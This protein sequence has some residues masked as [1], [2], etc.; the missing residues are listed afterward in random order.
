M[1]QHKV[2]PAVK[3]LQA[4]PAQLF[5]QPGAL[6][7]QQGAGLL[8]MLRLAQR[9]QCR[10]LRRAVYSEAGPGGGHLPHQLP[11]GG[12]GI[13]HPQAGH[14]PCLGEAVHHHKTRAVHR[15][16]FEGMLL[17]VPGQLDEALVHH[18]Q[19]IPFGARL[20]QI[21]QLAA[22]QK[23]P[24][25]VARVAQH[26]HLGA[27]QRL[28]HRCGIRHKA[29]LRAG[30]QMHQLTA[31]RF[32]RPGVFLVCRLQNHRLFRADRP[33]QTPD[34][35]VRAGSHEHILGQHLVPVRQSCAQGGAVRVGICIGGGQGGG[36]GLRCCGRHTQRVAAA[37][38][39]Q[40]AHGQRRHGRGLNA[41]KLHQRAGQS[42]G[43]VKALLIQRP[44]LVHVPLGAG[45]G[46]RGLRPDHEGFSLLLQLLDAAHP[47]V[48]VLRLMQA[49]LH[50]LGVGFV[51]AAVHLVDGRALALFAEALLPG[52]HHHQLARREGQLLRQRDAAGDAA[53]QADVLA[54]LHH[55]AQQR[56]AA[57]GPAGG[58]ELLAHLLVVVEDGL[59]GAAVGG[60]RPHALLR[61][62]EGLVI[63]GHQFMAQLAEHKIKVEEAEG[64]QQM[65]R[66]HIPGIVHI[67]QVDVPAAARLAGQIT[68]GIQR[69]GAHAHHVGNPDSQL[70]QRVQHTGGIHPPQCA[71]FQNQCIGLVHVLSL[72]SSG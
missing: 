69:T 37:G 32:Q 27:F 23:G 42:H 29:L 39:I 56:H 17:P 53:V 9:R 70:H 14:A 44:Q 72:T 65:G 46:D 47:A 3:H 10:G 67:I 8:Q 16:L 30:H 61:F 31:L 40:R 1:N 57:A 19:H 59:A 49:G 25:G 52:E 7:L 66:P 35:L 48:V 71:A 22:G 24:G 11:V 5:G 55:A 33:N 50:Q 15:I 58:E 12:D 21:H 51:T 43:F 4:Q 6:G 64:F 2:H 41:Q 28:L 18:T 26:Q 34:H 20:H 68:Q 38:C 13:A 36:S 45:H 54:H 60:H 62:V 63:E